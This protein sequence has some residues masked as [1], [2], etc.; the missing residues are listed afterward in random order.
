[1]MSQNSTRHATGS[2]AIRVVIWLL[3]VVATAGAVLS[4]DKVLRNRSADED[5]GAAAVILPPP[6]RGGDR[7]AG[8]AAETATTVI[9]TLGVGNEATSDSARRDDA[10]RGGGV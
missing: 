1:M 5:A 3:A 2:L 9:G 10:G 7:N 4:I 6:S 8:K